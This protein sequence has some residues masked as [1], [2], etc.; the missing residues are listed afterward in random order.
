MGRGERATKK[1]LRIATSGGLSKYFARQQDVER[2]NRLKREEEERKAALELEKVIEE[3]KK[4]ALQKIIAECEHQSTQLKQKL[5]KRKPIKFLKSN[6]CHMNMKYQPGLNVDCNQME[7]DNYIGM[8]FTIEKYAKNF[9][10]YGPLIADIE[11]PDDARVLPVGGLVWNSDTLSYTFT[12]YVDQW[13]TD[14]FILKNIRQN[15]F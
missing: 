10:Y 11:F 9:K 12:T 6:M 7:L 1:R 15:P 4:V 5:L 13:R 2:R 8:H 14:K 3:K